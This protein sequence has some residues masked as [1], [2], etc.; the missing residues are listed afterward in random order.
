MLFISKAVNKIKEKYLV[1][2]YSIALISCIMGNSGMDLRF[3]TVDFQQKMFSMCKQIMA[4][5][6]VKR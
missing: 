1:A 6:F 3:S 5:E 4:K 2:K